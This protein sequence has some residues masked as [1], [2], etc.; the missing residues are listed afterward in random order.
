MSTMRKQQHNVKSVSDKNH[1][2]SDNLK[3]QQQ[4]EEQ[5]ERERPSHLKG[6]RARNGPKE[7]STSRTSASWCVPWKIYSLNS[8]SWKCTMYIIIILKYREC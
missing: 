3:S 4:E 1:L 8:G 7:K 5:R 6:K 2:Q